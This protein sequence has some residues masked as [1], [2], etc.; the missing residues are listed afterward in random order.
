MSKNQGA[1]RS[2][3]NSLHYSMVA[4]RRNSHDKKLYATP[5]AM[6]VVQKICNEFSGIYS[7]SAHG[8][9]QTIKH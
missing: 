6:L 5:L 3:I 9:N 2:L 4:H 1:Y 7:A 8:I